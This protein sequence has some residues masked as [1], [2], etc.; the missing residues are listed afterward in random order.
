SR[1]SVLSN[2]TLPERLTLPA[3]VDVSLH[4]S[5]IKNRLG[6]IIWDQWKAYSV[7]R[8]VGNEWLLLPKGFASFVAR[9]PGKLASY[10][11]DAV[12]YHYK[13]HYPSA[14]PFLE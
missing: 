8:G 7:A 1:L 4:D 12:H 14:V 3:G 2:S 5:A 6:R 11:M 9:P 10:G 13:K